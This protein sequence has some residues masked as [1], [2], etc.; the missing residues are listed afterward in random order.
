MADIG[1]N[2]CNMITCRDGEHCLF[3]SFGLGNSTD[4]ANRLSRSRL[5][6][7]VN[8]WFPGNM[9]E[10]LSVDRASISGEFEY[11]LSVKEL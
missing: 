11:S 8:R 9:V 5:Q 10:S 6:V 1:K 4:S 2:I 3:R 7:E